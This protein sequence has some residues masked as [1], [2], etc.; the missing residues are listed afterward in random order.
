M[1]KT[2]KDWVATDVR[3]VRGRSI[4]WLSEH[5][6][7]RDPLRPVLMD[8]RFLFAP[9]DGV[10]LYQRRVRP[11]EPLLEIKGRPYSVRDALRDE[12]YGAECLVIGIFMT[13][14]DVHVNRVPYAGFLN[15]RE[16]DPLETNNR[17]MLDMET[18]LLEELD[19][20]PETAG[21]LHVNQRVVNRIDSP[22]LG[23]SYHVLQVADYDVDCVT[24]F[25]LKQNV[26]FSQNCR[27]SQIR[28]G[29]QV[30]LIVPLGGGLDF[31][32]VQRPGLHVEAGRDTLLRIDGLAED[33]PIS[34]PVAAP[35]AAAGPRPRR[36]SR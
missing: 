19:I 7:F 16:L 12:S 15:W 18:A 9:A 6:F 17:P 36:T 10:I 20:L 35:A 34:L 3:R 4:R 5:Y 28:Y 30:D 1:A 33:H 22:R 25:E 32:F 2:L 8:S 14:Y 13:F 24:P 21:Y 23:R 31:E 26:P 29:S 11:D 27:F